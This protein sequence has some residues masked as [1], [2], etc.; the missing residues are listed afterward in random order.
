MTRKIEIERF[1]LTSSKP[2]DQVIAALHAAIGHPHMA[3][4][5]R[6]IERAQSFTDLESTIQKAV[7]QV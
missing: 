4:F 3:E 7:G 5:W 6:L 2:F 1:T